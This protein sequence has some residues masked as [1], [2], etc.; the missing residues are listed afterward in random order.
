[1]S[2][3][4]SFLN[5]SYRKNERN[6]GGSVV[7]KRPYLWHSSRC[8]PLK[9]HRSYAAPSPVTCAV[10]SFVWTPGHKLITGPLRPLCRCKITWN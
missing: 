7:K 10:L 2:L 3:Q 4:D 6:R 8:F 1:M 9:A 5:L